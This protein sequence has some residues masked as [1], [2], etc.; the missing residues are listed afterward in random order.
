MV[1]RYPRGQ[2]QQQQQQAHALGDFSS[3]SAGSSFYNGYHHQPDS[4]AQPL[5]SGSQ[6][7]TS[8]SSPTRRSKSSAT[9][10]MNAAPTTMLHSTSADGTSE[11]TV[12]I[13]MAYA[14]SSSSSPTGSTPPVPTGASCTVVLPHHHHHASTLW[15]AYRDGS[16][17]VYN[18]DAAAPVRDVVRVIPPS[19]FTCG[20]AGSGFTSGPSDNFRATATLVS[21]MLQV[22]GLVWVATGEGKIHAF[23][24]ATFRR[25]HETKH[26]NG[27]VPCMVPSGDGAVVYTGGVDG[28]VN[29]WSTEDVRYLRNVHVGSTQAVQC[30]QP[31][32][33]TRVFCGT[34]S[35][36]VIHMRFN[37]TANPAPTA[38]PDVWRGHGDTVTVLA[39]HAGYLCS[40]STDGTVRVWD[41]ATAKTLCILRRPEGHPHSA[42]DAPAARGSG[43]AHNKVT[44]MLSL[45]HASGGLLVVFGGTVACIFS[46]DFV[47]EHEVG[48]WAARPS[49]S[50]IP[51]QE[52]QDRQH[53]STVFWCVGQD[54]IKRLAVSRAV[55]HLSRA[56]SSI[57]TASS[58]VAPTP[59]STLAALGEEVARLRKDRQDMAATLR[60][61]HGLILRE[62][63]IIKSLT[64]KCRAAEAKTEQ[65]DCAVVNNERLVAM[66]VK[67]RDE[68][69]AALAQRD[70]E[71]EYL[72]E[73]NERLSRALE[74]AGVL[75][76]TL[77]RKIELMRASVPPMASWETESA[78]TESSTLSSTRGSS[79]NNVTG[80][81]AS[82]AAGASA[83]EYLDVRELRKLVEVKNSV[84]DTLQ[85]KLNRVS[86]P[87]ASEMNVDNVSKMMESLRARGV[88]WDTL[89]RTH[90]NEGLVAAEHTLTVDFTRSCVHDLVSLLHMCYKEREGAERATQIQLRREL[91]DLTIERDDA[92]ALRIRATQE[93][94]DANDMID[95]LEREVIRAE[96]VV[97]KLTAALKA[98]R[99][100][101]V[102]VGA[103]VVAELERKRHECD[104][105]GEDVSALRQRL[106]VTERE[107]EA[108]GADLDVA[109]EERAR[110]Q[111]EIS[112][113]RATYS[114]DTEMWQAKLEATQRELYTKVEALERATTDE[115]DRR[116]S[117]E[118][119]IVELEA[120]AARL[121]TSHV[122]VNAKEL[123][124]VHE[125]HRRR[126]TGL[127]EC[128][129]LCHALRLGDVQAQ[130]ERARKVHGQTKV[131]LG[132]AT[133]KLAQQSSEH[134]KS[135]RHKDEVLR[136]VELELAQGRDKITALTRE[137]RD[138]RS[139]HA[140][141]ETQLRETDAAATTLREQ[142][143]TNVAELEDVRH[144]LVARETDVVAL[145]KQLD[146][147]LG[148]PA[149]SAVCTRTPMQ[150]CS[151]PVV[152]ITATAVT[153]SRGRSG[154]RPL[155]ASELSVRPDDPVHPVTMLNPDFD[156]ANDECEPVVLYPDD[157]VR[158]ELAEEDGEDATTTPLPLPSGDVPY[159]DSVPG[160][161]ESEA[162]D[163]PQTA[164]SDTTTNS[165]RRGS[166]PPTL[167]FSRRGSLEGEK[168]PKTHTGPVIPALR[169]S[170]L[171]GVDNNN[172]ISKKT[173]ASTLIN[174][175]KG[176]TTG[177][178]ANIN[179]QR[180]RSVSGQSTQSS[181][182][183]SRHHQGIISK[184]KPS[185]GWAHPLGP[186]PV[187][188][189][190]AGTTTTS[191][192]SKSGVGLRRPGG[193]GVV[194]APKK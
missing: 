109:E 20:L 42:S 112:H 44:A 11:V 142:L 128:E 75:H 54:G 168:K 46:D 35:G 70:S 179:F 92:D 67:L 9:N 18:A 74:H 6:H 192:S 73:S 145:R 56:P 143:E 152:D 78:A 31:L 4:A 83:G 39:V 86:A 101:N 166:L 32:D 130:L 118:H 147:L 178:N 80:E 59:S 65:H 98:A 24:A 184:T 64:D 40:G 13:A 91:R 22:R 140:E 170:V 94:D 177:N 30:I 155:E 3:S 16:I 125:Q 114:E 57:P 90:T 190:A 169:M 187:T 97:T 43:A 62:R 61:A 124:V 58:S 5:N 176:P 76:G 159:V 49:A 34:S 47:L 136:G 53:N 106:D 138:C 165:S 45:S 117:A 69:Q 127:V 163:A 48:P 84:I 113:L 162:L 96:D 132:L 63:E 55:T 103:D 158:Q 134:S 194:A 26:H 150:S 15:A 148:G 174:Q 135:F 85:K 14:P 12:D 88:E 104:N 171:T 81:V 129:R 25:V 122:G 68:C 27:A 2:Q 172:T 72:K 141:T 191:T 8:A 41:V 29:V 77:L 180:V 119:R 121:R 66:G 185:L 186:K 151:P 182:S 71:V 60:D 189:G 100:E 23:E 51:A 160:S 38:V 1:L 154:S 82:S 87:T 110:M 19:T 156:E 52:E 105:L 131:S 133:A 193:G 139:A 115:T 89:L 126:T 183:S 144:R 173:S 123:Q 99:Q 120:E 93:R 102:E 50:F 157:E 161:V 108:A 17:V 10:S 164:H 146:I 116:V 111:E 95:T 21:C 153:A 181:S 175:K 33:E 167:S 36:G 107:L 137:L 188:R 37:G 28:R 79:S 7:N 149:T